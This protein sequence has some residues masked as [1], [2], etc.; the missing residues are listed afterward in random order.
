[1]ASGFD[2][3]GRATLRGA[4]VSPIRFSQLDRVSPYRRC[5]GV[6]RAQKS[7]IGFRVIITCTPIWARS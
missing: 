5:P 6:F 7:L 1:M 3:L 2:A 4:V